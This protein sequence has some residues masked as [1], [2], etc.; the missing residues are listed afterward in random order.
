MKLL[1]DCGKPCSPPSVYLRK[2]R[3]SSFV[4]SFTAHFGITSKRVNSP[5]S[6]NSGD[7][8]G[9]DQRNKNG[10]VHVHVGFRLLI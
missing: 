1:A 4:R 5:A 2:P 9:S 3:S 6:S 8:P 7:Y 10:G